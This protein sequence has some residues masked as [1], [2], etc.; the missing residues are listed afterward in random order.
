LKTLRGLPPPAGTDPRIDLLEASAQVDQDFVAAQAAAKRAIAKG[1][2]LGSHLMVA[3]AY[4]ILCQ[5]GPAMGASAQEIAADCENA[6]ESYASAGDRNNEARTLNDFAGLYFHQGDLLKSVSM[7]RE[8][9]REFSQ[10]GDTEGLAAT[11]NNIGDVFLTQGKLAE[12]KKMLEQAMRSY[13][14]TEDNAGVALV[15]NDL[16]DIAREQGDLGG[17][18][19]TYQQARTIAL[20]TGDKSV[21][22]YVLLGLG[23]VLKYRGE[24]GTARKSYEESL[25]LRNQTGEKQ[26][27]AETQFALALLS[28]EDG[29]PVDAESVLRKCIVQFHQEQQDDD[30][31]SGRVALIHALLAQGKNADAKAE[32]ERAELLAQKSQ[33]FLARLHFGLASARVLLT[34][35]HPESS[36]GQLEQILK[37]AHA[38]GFASLEFEARLALAEM[39]KRTGRLSTAQAQLASLER[40]AS[41]KGFGLIA[42]KA[43]AARG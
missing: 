28:I 31:L 6:R 9:Q 18:E 27:L 35:D 17:A 8:A 15:L 33:N 29:R 19:T 37:D 7:W 3:R 38:R 14:A 25:A 20:E 30:E 4:G 43:A 24:L 42:R 16:G 23:D 22:A 5:Q 12:A 34:S 26:A 1:T 21:L 10:F 36:R 11:A 41:A 40:V 39:E 2:A 32:M 13:Q